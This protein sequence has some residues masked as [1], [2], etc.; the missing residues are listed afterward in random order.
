MKWWPF[1]SRKLTAPV[2][3]SQKQ[4]I[5][6]SLNR[7]KAES[8]HR[9]ESAKTKLENAAAGAVEAVD[10]RREETNFLRDAL[11]TLIDR[12]THGRFNMQQHRR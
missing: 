5:E 12:R 4:Q 11:K 6:E 3:E 2:S 7:I 9:V 8:D 1:G 10:R